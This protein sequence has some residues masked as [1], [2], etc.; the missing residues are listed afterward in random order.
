MLSSNTHE[1]HSM[2]GP[3]TSATAAIWRVSRAVMN[4]F[5]LVLFAL[6]ALAGW[7]YF[8][9]SGSVHAFGLLVVNTLFVTLF[10]FR[11][12]AKIE[13]VSPGLWVLGIAGTALPLLMRP[14]DASSLARG[15]DILQIAGFV[16]LAAA[17][18]SLRRSFGIVAANRGVRSGGLY[19]FVRHP[20]YFSELTLFLGFVLANPTW[21]NIVI[22]LCECVLQYA[23]AC[24]EERL[25]CSDPAYRYY[26]S[27]VRYRL[28]PGLI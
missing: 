23:R 11:S 14:C 24:A 8:V 25:L 7:R 17:L 2:S 12:P 1:H 3:V 4:I 22:W 27:E 15:G 6:Q 16:L 19:R 18:L 21:I 9:S 28:V 10:M 5:I 26:R 20:V 13:S